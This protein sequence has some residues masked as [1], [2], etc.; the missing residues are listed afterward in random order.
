MEIPLS[1]NRSRR[2]Y[3]QILRDVSVKLAFSPLKVQP[4]ES[5]DDREFESGD[6]EYRSLSKRRGTD[7]WKKR[8]I[9]IHSYRFTV[10]KTVPEKV[11]AWLRKIKATARTTAQTIKSSK[12]CDISLAS[13]LKRFDC[14]SVGNTEYI[15]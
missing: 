11:K 4:R 7:F 12:Y 13:R 10:K 3:S 2:S 5:G 8:Q 9:F 14:C 6:E 15:N 1:N